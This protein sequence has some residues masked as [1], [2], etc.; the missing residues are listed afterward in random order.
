MISFES[1]R[2][3]FGALRANRWWAVVI[4]LGF[5]S[6]VGVVFGIHPA[7]KAAQLDPVAALRDA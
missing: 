5:C 4:S 2:L 3:A 6:L 1:F 7:G